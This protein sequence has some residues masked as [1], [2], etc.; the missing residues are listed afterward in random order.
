MSTQRAGSPDRD[1]IDELLARATR[2]DRS[3]DEPSSRGS[4]RRAPRRSPVADRGPRASA[5][6]SVYD[7]D[8]DEAEGMAERRRVFGAAFA[9]DEAAERDGEDLESG[10]GD[11]SDEDEDGDDPTA[12][13]AAA[14]HW[15]AFNAAAMNQQQQQHSAATSS[16]GSD[17]EDDDADD[18]E[19]DDEDGM[20][21]LAGDGQGAR[22]GRLNVVDNAGRVMGEYQPL[23]K[24][25]LEQAYRETN[26]VPKFA[27]KPAAPAEKR[28]RDAPLGDAMDAKCLNLLRECNV[29][30]SPDFLRRLQQQRLHQ[31]RHGEGDDEST[32]HDGARGAKRRRTTDDGAHSTDD[33]RP[34]A[35]VYGR[36]DM[37]YVARQ[38]STML[39]DADVT[40]EQM[41]DFFCPLC[42]FG[43]IV[44][45][46][47]VNA[48]MFKK[49][50]KVAELGTMVI[51]NETLAFILAEMWNTGIYK[52]MKASNKRITPFTYRMAYEHLKK[53]HRP[54]PRPDHKNDIETLGTIVSTMKEMIFYR[55]P[56][57]R[58][59]RY[60]NKAFGMT[61]AAI[62][63]KNSLR[64]TLPEKMAYYNPRLDHSTAAAS[65]LVNPF[66]AIQYDVGSDPTKRRKNAHAGSL[67]GRQ[68]GKA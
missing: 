47:P 6:N 24:L 34:D 2:R 40:V 16:I 8:D 60:D 18:D 32:S 14:A 44:N 63:L 13:G 25:T 21:G 65:G 10:D 11:G 61:M 62:R 28:K 39:R 35:E 49:I 23:E 56:V 1:S 27:R 54:D 51:N 67:G 36:D 57:T 38:F 17:D 64:R 9:E 31:H 59:L 7:E 30:E 15:G 50:E 19:E 43:N 20:E 45:E 26:P 5:S 29:D 52:T 4:S 33:E 48:K 53:P 68:T 37:A 46:E 66:K 22:A 55:D 41:R 58:R 12:F 3:A 42:G